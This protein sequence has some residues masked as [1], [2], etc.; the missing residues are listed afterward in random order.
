MRA[1]ETVTFNGITF[2][3][4]PEA[5]QL[6]HRRYYSPSGSYKRKG[7]QALHQEIW[8]AAHGPIPENHHVHH[9]DGNTSNNSLESLECIPRKRHLSQHSRENFEKD[10][11]RALKHLEEIRSMAT[12][13][14]KSEDGHRWH[15]EHGKNVFHNL[16]K[17]TF[18]CEFCSKVFEHVTRHSRFCSNNCKAASRRRDGVDNITEHCSICGSGFT[19]NRYAKTKTCSRVCAKTA[20]QQTIGHKARL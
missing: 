3:R 1:V 20:R 7:I 2:R 4:Y 6:S 9:I 15:V 19:K 12:E 5:R 11:D 8:K 10:P 18:T 17:L 14:H 16:S 13:W